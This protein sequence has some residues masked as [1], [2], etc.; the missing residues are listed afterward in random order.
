MRP[1]GISE[2]ARLSGLNKST[3][4]GLVTALAEEGF[5]RSLEDP[6]G[7]RGYV[8]GPQLLEL[9]QRARNRQVLDEAQLQVDRLAQ[10]IGETVLFGRLS[11]DRVVILAR[12]ESGQSLKLSAPLGSSVPLLAGALGKAYAATLPPGAS[13]P[14]GLALSRFTERSITALRAFRDEVES[15]R[16]R[17]F[18]TERGEYLPGVTAAA[19]CF[20]AGGTAYFLWSIGI[21]AVTSD[22]DL[23]AAGEALRGAANRIVSKLENRHRETAR[24]AS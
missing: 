8:L 10:E 18:A 5:L 11:G 2:L 23:A 13:F 21:D 6:G 16:R 20:V 7:A 9:G 14:E 22:G 17:G 4:H 24:S 1:L 3:V 12:A 15:A 19:V